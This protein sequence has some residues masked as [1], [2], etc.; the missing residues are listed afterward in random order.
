MCNACGFTCCAYDGFS[1]C[2]CDD[3]PERAC[4]DDDD[5]FG[6]DDW[7]DDYVGLTATGLV[8]RPVTHPKTFAPHP[9]R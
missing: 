2:G 1:R 9:R 3:C 5:D 7:T 8:A 6:D 4:W